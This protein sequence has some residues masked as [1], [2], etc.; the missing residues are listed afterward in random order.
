MNTAEAVY[1]LHNLRLKFCLSHTSNIYLDTSIQ[2][3]HGI[4]WILPTKISVPVLH[5]K[6]HS[7]VNQRQASERQPPDEPGS[8]QNSL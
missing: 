4:K 8:T 5:A 7:T 3:G 1:F 2:I 6:A